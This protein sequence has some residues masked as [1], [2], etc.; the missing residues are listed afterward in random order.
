VQHK[1][2]NFVRQGTKLA[3]VAWAFFGA[4]PA[5]AQADPL[6]DSGPT[7]ACAAGV[8]FAPGVDV[9]GNAVVPADTAGRRVPVPD[10]IAIPISR[11]RNAPARPAPGSGRDRQSTD[12]ASSNASN[13]D[14]AYVALDGRKLEPL[15]NPPP[16]NAVH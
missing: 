2:F 14:S 8:D 12:N 4:W 9:S 5:L 10:S 6:L 16:C 3:A 11:N 13:R 1:Q 7:V 15:L